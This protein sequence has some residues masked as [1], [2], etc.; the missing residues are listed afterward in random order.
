MEGVE[1]GNEIRVDPE[2]SFNK[3]MSCILGLREGEFA[4]RVPITYLFWPL[5]Q[6]T[7]KM[8]IKLK[9]GKREKIEDCCS[10]SPKRE[11]H[12]LERGGGGD[13]D[14]TFFSQMAITFFS[15]NVNVHYF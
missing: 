14:I 15:K 13:L 8:F 6:L 5:S 7:G 12:L 1:A 4:T 9:T 11:R 2:I 10:N 3:V